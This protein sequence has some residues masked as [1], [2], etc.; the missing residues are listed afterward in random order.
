VNRRRT[1]STLIALL[2]AGSLGVPRASCQ[3][4]EEDTPAG[5]H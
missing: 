3:R 1:T 4:P 5:R 2:H